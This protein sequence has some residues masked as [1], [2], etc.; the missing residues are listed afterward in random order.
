MSEPNAAPG[1]TGATV[2]IFVVHDSGNVT[3][4]GVCENAKYASDVI[5]FVI[6]SPRGKELGVDTMTL[7]YYCEG[8]SNGMTFVV[9]GEG[10][11][12]SVDNIFLLPGKHVCFHGADA[13]AA[14]R[15]RREAMSMTNSPAAPIHL[16]R[17]TT[18]TT[19]PN[20]HD[21]D[22]VGVVE[23]P[24]ERAAA[25]ELMEK[26][27]N[28][29]LERKLN[30]T[31]FWRGDA[32]SGRIKLMETAGMPG[33]GKTAL[34]RRCVQK[35]NEDPTR[36]HAV[37][38]SFSGTKN[39]LRDDYLAH[40][41][42]NFY[43]SKAFA[44]ALLN[45]CLRAGRTSNEGELALDTECDFRTAIKVYRRHAKVPDSAALM[46]MVD[47]IGRLDTLNAK[48]LATSLME[49][50]DATFKS[51]HDPAG[52]GVLPPLGFVFSAIYSSINLGVLNT[53]S[54]R[55]VQLLPLQ[56]LAIDSWRQVPGAEAYVERHPRALHLFL[57]CA[58]HPRLI[59]ERLPG[60]IRQNACLDRELLERTRSELFKALRVAVPLDTA[61]LISA[62]CLWL[63]CPFTNRAD[64]FSEIMRDN[65]MD[66]GLLHVK[67]QGTNFS[68]LQPL[69][70]ASAAKNTGDA[71]LFAALHS[72]YEADAAP[73]LDNER[74]LE[75]VMLHF[76]ILQRIA[77][78][79]P[80]APSPVT[81]GMIFS[82]SHAAEKWKR[83]VVTVRPLKKPGAVPVT[84]VA[85][86]TYVKDFSDAAKIIG[87]LK[88]GQIVVSK[89]ATEE[90]VE[91][92]SPFFDAKNPTKL[93]I[94]G[95]QCKFSP[96]PTWDELKTKYTAAMKPFRKLGAETF[97]VAYTASNVRNMISNVVKCGFVFTARDLFL[98]TAHLGVLRIH[99]E[100][101]KP[102]SDDGT[103]LRRAILG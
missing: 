50:S 30:D 85:P 95:V 72:Y 97:L 68:M 103:D 38:F 102:T 69:I 66:H 24:R 46:F 67:L 29:V 56:P 62:L 35:L 16:Y 13:L 19:F 88:K 44:Y 43:P 20:F 77:W 64:G 47:E 100:K 71:P 59:F 37:Y 91:Y 18:T 52:T 86:Y 80:D 94:A 27:A 8:G 87:I 9:D 74:R 1:H 34:L 83:R 81:L 6:D 57:L 31:T 79:Q 33:I 26:Y 3:P 84:A 11:P 75:E 4:I 60:V 76:Q 2:G 63:R 61:F 49:E 51:A 99:M 32:F 36:F 17:L 89:K 10:K 58:G 45:A 93:I 28:A 41:R 82:T 14:K 40:L 78:T 7:F 23:E 98:H 15:A 90:G 22:D 21:I 92:L 25:V 70:W 48:E 54:Q 42:Q 96:G 73:G 65:L 5:N 53:G 12:R 55:L 39:P 101:M